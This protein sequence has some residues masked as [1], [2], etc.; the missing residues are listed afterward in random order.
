MLSSC[1]VCTENV[2]FFHFQPIFHSIFVLLQLQIKN[3]KMLHFMQKKQ[4]KKR[5]PTKTCAHAHT[6]TQTHTWSRN[7]PMFLGKTIV[8]NSKELD[9][10]AEE[11]IPFR[12]ALRK[13]FAAN[14]SCHPNIDD[15][16]ILILFILNHNISTSFY[17]SAM[18]LTSSGGCSGTETKNPGT[19]V[20]FWDNFVINWQFK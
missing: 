8:Q 6:H 17:T 16:Y 7:L 13:H 19:K 4:P 14:P 3:S 9:L 18:R 2:I 12:T 15:H 11:V 1:K 20:Y 10:L 5:V